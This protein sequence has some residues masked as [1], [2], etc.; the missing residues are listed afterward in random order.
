[1]LGVEL[2]ELVELFEADQALKVGGA[3][4]EVFKAD[5]LPERSEN[6]AEGE[7]PAEMI[8][9]ATSS[10]IGQLAPS[11]LRPAPPPSSLS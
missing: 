7:P 10:G 6:I 4:G 3:A 11:P 9:M 1:M 5:Q 8:A 2:V